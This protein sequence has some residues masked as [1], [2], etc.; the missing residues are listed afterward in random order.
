MIEREG[1]KERERKILRERHKERG[2]DLYIS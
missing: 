2:K 1:L